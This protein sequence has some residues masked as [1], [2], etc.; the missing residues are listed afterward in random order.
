[1]WLKMSDKVLCGISIHSLDAYGNDRSFWWSDGLCPSTK[2]EA[3]SDSTFSWQ[4]E[5]ENTVYR[6]LG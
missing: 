5:T 4:T 3:R 1:M 6:S 2:I